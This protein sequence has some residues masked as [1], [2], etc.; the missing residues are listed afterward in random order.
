[1]LKFI[2]FMA[3]RIYYKRSYEVDMKKQS[4]T[5]PIGKLLPGNKYFL[6][7]ER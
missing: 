5:I 4:K 3:Y 2:T 7:I 1:M 6:K